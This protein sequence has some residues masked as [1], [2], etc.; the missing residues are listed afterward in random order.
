MV[1]DTFQPWLHRW[2]C[3]GLKDHIQKR[4]ERERKPGHHPKI[5]PQIVILLGTTRLE[6]GRCVYVWCAHVII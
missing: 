1:K 4:Q 2:I 6:D 5:K 3:H